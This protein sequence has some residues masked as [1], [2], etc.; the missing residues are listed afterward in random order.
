VEHRQVTWLGPEHR[1]D[2]EIE[3]EPRA[4]CVAVGQL[5]RLERLSVEARS[6]W[7]RPRPIQGDR[8]LE[9]YELAEQPAE[10]AGIGLGQRRYQAGEVRLRPR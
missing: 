3:Q 5:E 9:L 7:R 2:G 1:P 10:V 4:S 8:R 6:A